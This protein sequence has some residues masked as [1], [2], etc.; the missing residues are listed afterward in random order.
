MAGYFEP[1]GNNGDVSKPGAL[2]QPMRRQGQVSRPNA[3]HKIFDF[4]WPTQIS[5]AFEFLS[6]VAKITQE[7]DNHIGINDKTAAEFLINLHDGSNQ[8]LVAFKAKVKE[9]G[10]EFPDSFI[11]N[12]GRLI[13]SMHPKYKKRHAKSTNGKAKAVDTELSEL[14]RKKRLFSGL[15][16]KDKD[17]PPA[18]DNAFLQEL[19]DLVSGRKTRPHPTD[20]P[21]PKRQRRSA[22]PRR[23]PSPRGRND[24]WGN[25]NGGGKPMDNKPILFTIYGG[26]VTGLK[27]FGAFVTLEGVSGR[28]EG[29]VTVL[30]ISFSDSDSFDR[31]GSCL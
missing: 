5:T 20:E 27:D 19:G 31:Y 29:T 21:A 6:L 11:E 13:L 28:V 24:R 25:R 18:S 2:E 9:I 4:P 15:A 26:K 22:S 17:V 23:S 14:D 1:G 8:S 3:G 30:I 12:V 7:I 16:V 10:L